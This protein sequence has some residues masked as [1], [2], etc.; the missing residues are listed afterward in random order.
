MFEMSDLLPYSSRGVAFGNHLAIGDG[1][2]LVAIRC[3][4]V[5]L[6]MIYLTQGF[7]RLAIWIVNSSQLIIPSRADFH[8]TTS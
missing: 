5:T 8:R 4:L 2:W 7:G 1:C 3:G 6:R